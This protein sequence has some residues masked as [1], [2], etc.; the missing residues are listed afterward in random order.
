[1]LIERHRT[2][3]DRTTHRTIRGGGTDKGNDRTRCQSRR[4]LAGKKGKHRRQVGGGDPAVLIG[5]YTRAAHDSAGVGV[6]QQRPVPVNEL[7]A[8]LIEIGFADD[9]IAVGI[10]GERIDRSRRHHRRCRKHG[11]GNHPPCG[12]ICQ[13][14]SHLRSVASRG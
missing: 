2:G 1:M 8:Q 11:N 9:T 14:P 4:P 12:G 7:Q 3:I 13:P 10:A 6:T 5:V